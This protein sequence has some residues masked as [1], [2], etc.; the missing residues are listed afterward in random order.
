M[1]E[2]SEG[3]GEDWDWAGEPEENVSSAL[4]VGVES[5]FY[6]EEGFVSMSARCEMREG[7]GR[8][9]RDSGLTSSLAAGASSVPSAEALGSPFASRT[10]A[11]WA[12]FGASVSYTYAHTGFSISVQRGSE[13]K[14]K[15]KKMV[16]E[17]KC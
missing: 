15:W 14:R 11:S 2:D 4:G 3:E 16:T 17:A 6:G 1:G 7:V 12:S 5:D 10:S 13:G 8:G 9:I